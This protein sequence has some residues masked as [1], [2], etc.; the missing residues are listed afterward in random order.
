MCPPFYVDD[1]V[2]AGFI[3]ALSCYVY[4]GRDVP[5]GRLYNYGDGCCFVV[6]L[7]LVET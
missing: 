5:A 3:P 2:G 6:C 1:G 7:Y 4:L